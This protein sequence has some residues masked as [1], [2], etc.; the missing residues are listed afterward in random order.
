MSTSIFRKKINFIYTDTQQ[1]IILECLKSETTST[2]TFHNGD[3]TKQK[4][5]GSVASWHSK[6]SSD[7]GKS[8]PKTLHLPIEKEGVYEIIGQQII[9]GLYCFYKGENGRYY[10]NKIDINE[11]NEL[12]EKIKQGMSFKNSLLAMGRTKLF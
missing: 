2:L 11:K 9:S 10:Y 12:F 3:G 6:I 4:I 7:K 8:K 1:Y 5:N